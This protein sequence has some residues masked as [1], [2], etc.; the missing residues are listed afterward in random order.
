MGRRNCKKCNTEKNLSEF[1]DMVDLN[2]SHDCREC[3]NA[4]TQMYYKANK[5]RIRENERLRRQ[6]H[7]ASVTR[8]KNDWSKI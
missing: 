5:Q 3:R 7:K 2:K 6:R 4:Y 1:C 8:L